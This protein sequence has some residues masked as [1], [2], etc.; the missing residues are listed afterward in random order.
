MDA[1]MYANLISNFFSDG[2]L[3]SSSPERVEKCLQY[4]MRETSHSASR[5]FLKKKITSVDITFSKK[6][7]DSK[8]TNLELFTEENQNWMHRTLEVQVKYFL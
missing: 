5:D 4:V 7:R 8:C 1:L 3:I 6:W 2:K